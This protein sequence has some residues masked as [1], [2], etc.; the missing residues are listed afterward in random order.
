MI[1]IG[2]ETLLKVILE[3]HLKCI[4]SF[5]MGGGE[6]LH[7]VFR[8]YRQICMYIE[9]LYPAHISEIKRNPLKDAEEVDGK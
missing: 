1:I 3:S 7:T 2:E 5:K 8:V 9:T 4:N 6:I